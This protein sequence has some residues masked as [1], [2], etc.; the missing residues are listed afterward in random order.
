MGPLPGALG[1]RLFRSTSPTPPANAAL[2]LVAGPAMARMLLRYRHR[3]EFAWK[4]GAP[5]T[6]PAAPGVV[7]GCGV[8]DHR[9]PARR[10]RR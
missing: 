10:D 6:G 2:A 1:A 7:T 9:S 3:F 8:S 4:R 5:A